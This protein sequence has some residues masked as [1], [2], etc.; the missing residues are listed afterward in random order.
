L[1]EPGIDNRR[2]GIK[3]KERNED[4]NNWSISVLSVCTKI[5]NVNKNHLFI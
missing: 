5:I 4:K 2:R 3:M 1:P